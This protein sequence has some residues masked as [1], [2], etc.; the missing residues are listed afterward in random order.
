RLGYVLTPVLSTFLMKR[1]LE[2]YFKKA[3]VVPITDGHILRT[4]PQGQGLFG[5]SSRSGSGR[6]LLAAAALIGLS[7]AAH[8]LQRSLRLKVSTGA[9]RLGSALP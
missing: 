6:M 8:V 4:S 7:T 2:H 1:G 9:M 5:Q 3:D